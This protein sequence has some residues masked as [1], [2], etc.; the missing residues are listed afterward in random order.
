MTHD[1][2]GLSSYSVGIIS[3]VESKEDKRNISAVTNMIQEHIK[4]NTLILL[5]ITM[6]GTY[7]APCVAGIYVR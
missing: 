6:R 5:T 1:M 2:Y 3:A 7:N 4:G